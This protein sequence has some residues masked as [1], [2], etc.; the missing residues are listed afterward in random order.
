MWRVVLARPED[1]GTLLSSE[2][3]A[4]LPPPPPPPPPS[5]LPPHHQHQQHLWP[6]Q[7]HYGPFQAH[8]YGHEPAPEPQQQPPDGA[9]QQ[10]QQQQQQRSLKRPM[11]DSDCDDVFSEE[12]GK[13][14]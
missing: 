3:T 14:P 2:L 10:Q 8:G 5:A 7:Q 9:Q 12:S 1:S 13:E 4:P 11:S 6:H